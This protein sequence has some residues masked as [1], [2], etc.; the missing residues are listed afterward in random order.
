MQPRFEFG[1]QVRVVRTLR[2]DG[3]FPGMNPG[4]VLVRMGSLGHVRNVGTFLQDQLIYAVHFFESDRVVGCREEELIPADDPWI[5]TRFVFRDKVLARISLSAGGQVVVAAGTDGEVV[6]VLRERPDGP[7]YHVNFAGRVFLV[8]E[9]A[10]EPR[11]EPLDVA[12]A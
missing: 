12:G 3:T 11:E 7:A 8:P 2:D 4:D 10:L 1:Q 6:K 9:P 5:P